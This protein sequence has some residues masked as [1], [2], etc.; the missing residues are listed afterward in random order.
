MNKSPLSRVR[1]DSNGGGG[2]GA[3]GRGQ[4]LASNRY[5]STANPAG[6]RR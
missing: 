4:G 3:G 1:H 5:G 6:R 2:G